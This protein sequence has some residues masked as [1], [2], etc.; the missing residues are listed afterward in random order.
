MAITFDGNVDDL[1]GDIEKL[2]IEQIEQGMNDL[3][4]DMVNSATTK[5]Y[6]GNPS[7]SKRT[8]RLKTD[9]V[10][11]SKVETRGGTIVG[12]V[13]ATVEYAEYVEEGTGEY[14]G[15]RRYLGKI[16]SLAGKNGSHDKGWRLIKGQKGKHFM[17]RTVEE[18]QPKVKNYFKLVRD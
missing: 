12:E 18:F 4:L 2:T 17:E 14:R 10:N 7:L 13:K 1:F 3:V 8:N 5:A 11:S 9:I 15:R 16:P 6:E